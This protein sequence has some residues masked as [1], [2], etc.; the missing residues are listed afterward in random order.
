M[1]IGYDNLVDNATLSASSEAAGYFVSNIKEQQLSKVWKSTS[2][3]GQWIL[4][5][6]G[7]AQSV[8]GVFVA[9][10]NLLSGSTIKIQANSSDDWTS[11]PVDESLTY[12]EI[13]YKLFSSAQSYRYWRVYLDDSSLSEISVGRVFLGD[14]LELGDIVKAEF[15]ETIKRTDKIQ[16]SISGEVFGDIGVDYRLFVFALP[17]IDS[18]EKANIETMYETVGKYK[19]VFMA[20]FDDITGYGIYYVVLNDDISFNHIIENIWNCNIA[21]REAK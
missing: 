18:T 8:K 20:Y 3:S 1:I 14:L 16:Y 10:H 2:G 11:P 13:C 12:G 21:F 4:I 7:S 17:H 6:F 19:P 9:G 5:D 15:P